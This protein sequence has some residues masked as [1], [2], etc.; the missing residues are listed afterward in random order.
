VDSWQTRALT[1]NC[2]IPASLFETGL[3][4]HWSG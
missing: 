3:K 2:L 4:F 1:G